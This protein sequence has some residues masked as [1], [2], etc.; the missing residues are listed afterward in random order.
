MPGQTVQVTMKMVLEFEG[1]F[2]VKALNPTT[3]ALYPRAAEGE[4]AADHASFRGARLAD[5]NRRKD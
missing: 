3:Q 2:V 5:T 1:R 4:F